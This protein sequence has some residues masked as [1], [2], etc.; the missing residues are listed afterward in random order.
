MIK[1]FEG[2]YSNLQTALYNMLN[3]GLKNNELIFTNGLR[4][5]GKTFTLRK[6]ALDNNLAIVLT[7]YKWTN[8]NY[9]YREK[10]NVFKPSDIP[11]LNIKGIKYVIDEMSEEDYK[12]YDVKAVTGFVNFDLDKTENNKPTIDDF[13]TKTLAIEI[14]ELTPKIQKARI[15]NDIGTYKNLIKAYTEVLS[16]YNSARNDKFR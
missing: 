3:K 9:E 15:N 11:T 13:V 10:I 7:D 16:L 1:I 5:I 14:Q 2:E 8:P 12:K 4:A 6:F